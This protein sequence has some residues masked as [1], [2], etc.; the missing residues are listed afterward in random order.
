MIYNTTLNRYDKEVLSEIFSLKKNWIVCDV[1]HVNDN[2]DGET[3][4]MEIKYYEKDSKY[5][6][7]MGGK[8]HLMKE[9]YFKH[10]RNKKLKK[11]SENIKSK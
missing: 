3:I 9:E 8:F 6:V 4:G 5:A 2:D 7:L 10:A 1:Y 11:I